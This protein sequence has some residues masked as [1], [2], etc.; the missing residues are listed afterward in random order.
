MNESRK[1]RIGFV[2]VGTM[3]QCAHLKNYSALSDLCEVVALAELKPEAARKVA[4]R[5]FVPSVYATAAEMLANEELDGIVASQ[6]FTRHGI[7]VPELLE[8]GIPLFTEKPIAGSIAVG[9]RIVEAVRNSGSFHMVGYHKRSD[10][11]TMAAKA[12]IE[13]LRESGELGEM[14]YIRITMPAGDWIAGGFA[15]FIRTDESAP[16][17]D[18]DPADDSLS[19]EDNQ[20]YISFVNYYIHQVNLM[21]HLLGEN[22]VVTHVDP[23]GVLLVGKSLGGIPCTIEMTPYETTVDWQESALVCFRKGWVR[24]EL[25]APVASNRAGRVTFFRDPG[26]G[27]QPEFVEPQMPW[28]HA[29]R[30]QA[31][32][33]IRAI[34]GEM[35]PPCEAAEALEDL[36][37][38]RQFL[39]QAHGV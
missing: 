27:A 34:K 18:W 14:T 28:I 11:A 37:V 6:P 3:G 26:N 36:R 17:M 23:T 24:L 39:K 16:S 33:F 13:R 9:E 29:M 8:A 19:K 25:P 38:A 35:Q 15:D 5:Y 10:P 20:A 22:Y 4:Q 1:V 2:G 12:E 30:Q 21:R 31:I 7:L 32:H